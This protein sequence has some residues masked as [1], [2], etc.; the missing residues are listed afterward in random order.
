[1]PK[2]KLAIPTTVRELRDSAPEILINISKR[3]VAARAML[4]RIRKILHFTRRA[5]DGRQLVLVRSTNQL[6]LVLGFLDFAACAAG[7][8]FE[9]FCLR[10]LDDELLRVFIT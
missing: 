5:Q 1:M 9:R 2:F 10:G 8:F 7:I 6:L 4:D 3:I